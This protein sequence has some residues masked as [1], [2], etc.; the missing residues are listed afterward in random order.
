MKVCILDPGVE[1]NQGTLSSNLGDLIIQE[2]VHR[3]IHSLFQQV[4]IVSISTQSPMHDDHID[5]LRA[6]DLTFVGGTN[7]LSSYM[8]KYKQWNIS[9]KRA[10]QIKNAVLLGV[11]WWQYQDS[12]SL[13]TKMLLNLALSR[14]FV[15]SVRDSYTLEKMRSMGYRNVM[16]TGCPTMW[17]LAGFQPEEYEKVKQSNVLVMLTDYYKSIEID[18]KLLDILFA[19]Y[20]DVYFWPQGRGDE[21]YIKELNYPVKLL[22]HNIA[23]F[24]EFLNT[25]ID[26]DY[27][28]TRLHGGVRCLLEKKRA[29]ILAVDNRAREIAKDTN[30]NVLDRKDIEGIANWING[31]TETKLA[32]NTENI[33]KWKRQF[34]K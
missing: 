20:K 14:D 13:Y 17:P 22:G 11:G 15:H 23:A 7:L 16:N 28:G 3:E 31:P 18:R 29:L 24:V 19:N 27:V 12:P 34:G 2:A 26:F 10:F 8:N 32:I 21:A 9:I 4:E 1:D 5:V 30:L 25:G 33:N 6:C